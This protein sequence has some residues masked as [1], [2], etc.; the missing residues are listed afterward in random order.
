[1]PTLTE[2][3]KHLLGKAQAVVD[4]AKAT[5]RDF[6]ASEE[7]EVQGVFSDIQSLDVKIQAAKKSDDLMA[8]IAGLGFGADED[9]DPAS[10]GLQFTAEQKA[11]LVHAVRT[12]GGYATQVRRKAPTTVGTL[13]PAF[14]ALVAPTPTPGGVVELRGLFTQQQAD[15]PTVRYY[16][17][18]SGTAAVVAEGALKPDAGIITT[19][20]D[21]ALTK[22]A[23][24]FKVSDELGEDAP[25]LARSIQDQAMRALF[26]AENTHIIG[27]LNAASGIMVATGTQAAALDALAAAIGAA[28]SANGATPR[29]VVASPVDVAKLRQL[30]A[31]TAGSYLLGDPL[32]S[33]P[34]AVWGVPLVSSPSATAGQLWLI[35]D[36]AGVFYSRG[37][38]VRVEVGY[39]MDDF[40]KNLVTTRVEE[41]VLCAITAPTRVTKLTL[42]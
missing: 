11:G 10:A 41:R 23:N 34:S 38:G 8:Q 7:T 28:E 27:A 39:E 33:A 42:T 6:T 20:V 30:K 32:G 5:G 37:T 29:A 12:K 14:G 35:G 25:Y 2:Q 31:A 16:T 21:R 19:P 4:R 13:L 18:T 40:T 17:M 26:S 15:G 3:R 22:L 24:T 9:D 1:M 36:G